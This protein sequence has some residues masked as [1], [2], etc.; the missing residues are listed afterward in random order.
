M[1]DSH[2]KLAPEKVCSCG[3]DNQ[4]SE[5]VRQGVNGSGTH[6]CAISLCV[7]LGDASWC[8]ALLSSASF[9]VSTSQRLNGFKD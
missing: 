3:A 8:L 9:I 2:G 5:T 4:A 1:C 6:Q 7:P